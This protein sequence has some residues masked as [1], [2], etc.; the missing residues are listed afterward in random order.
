MEVFN[1]RSLYVSDL[2]GTLLRSD[3][4]LS[5][6]SRDGL[7]SLL[8]E[9]VN[10]TV[11]SARSV[12]SLQ[13]VLVGLPFQLPV[14]EINGAFISDFVSGEHLIINDMDKAV[15]DKL[16]SMVIERGCSPFLST[17]NGEQDCLYFESIINE[18]MQWYHD[19][20]VVG[21]DKR[22]REVGDLPRIFSDRVVAFTVINRYEELK[23]LAGEIADEFSGRLETHFFDNPYSPGWWWLT[24]HD[25]KACKS[26]AVKELAEYAGFSPGDIVVFGDNLNDVKMFKAAA[27]AIAVEN[28]TSQIRQYATEVIGSNEEDSVVKY[29]EM[30]NSTN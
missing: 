1:N 8:N 30:D 28:A 2:D 26:I 27:R 11:A 17:F 7:I 6:Y 23:G 25:K 13:Q 19:N 20:R 15:I 16:Y 9:G 14:I 4:S 29:I 22:L 12:V 10:F 18:G 24:I 5:V 21:K 3:G